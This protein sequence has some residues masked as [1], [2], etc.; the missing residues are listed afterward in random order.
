[1]LEIEQPREPKSQGR[2]CERHRVPGISGT[3]GAPGD[4]RVLDLSLFGMAFESPS[5]LRVGERCFIELRHDRHSVSV[6][7]AIRWCSSRPRTEK[8]EKTGESSYRV[9][10]CFVDILRDESDSGIWRWIEIDPQARA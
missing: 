2:R 7:L 8:N 6:E 4:V 9:G 10:A 5:P 3:L 1:M